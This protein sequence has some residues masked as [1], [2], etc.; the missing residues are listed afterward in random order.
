MKRF[1][2]FFIAASFCFSGCEGPAVLFERPQ[3][4]DIKDEPC[5]PKTLTGSYLSLADS[6]V[7]TIADNFITRG[8]NIKYVMTKKELQTM[9]ECILRKD[10][11]YNTATNE[12]IC[13]ININDSLYTP[14]HLQDTLFIISEKNKLRKDKGYYF[15]NLE[16]HNGWEV[17]KIESGK[18]KLVL[19]FISDLQEIN[20]LKELTKITDDTLVKFNPN[21]DQ[22]RKF[23]K[24]KG[25][26]KKEE[27]VKLRY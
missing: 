23:I 13:V 24:S 18:G 4:V 20:N 15:L 14:Y 27:F 26:S 6:T 21:K 25:F 22:F 7:L 3:P 17:Q 16:Y 10:S 5:F 12:K 11:L 9:K 1:I 8:F 19:S 2:C